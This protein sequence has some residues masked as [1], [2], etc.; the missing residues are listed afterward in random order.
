MNYEA[1]T[2]NRQRSSPRLFVCVRAHLRSRTS[3]AEQTLLFFRQIVCEWSVQGRP[4][5]NRK[6]GPSDDFSLPLN[7]F[8]V[9]PQWVISHGQT[10]KRK[11]QHKIPAATGK[12]E[13]E[14]PGG[15][16]SRA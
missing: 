12:E 4:E 3:A 14:V 2:E 9:A 8:R 16:D 13:E 1:T 11:F 5:K 10:E 6:T 7:I 15:G